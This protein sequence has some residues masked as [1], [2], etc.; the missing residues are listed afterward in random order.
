M[1]GAVAVVAA[2]I[3][4]TPADGGPAAALSAE[5][6]P[7][8]TAVHALETPLPGTAAGADPATPAAL[9]DADDGYSD[10]DLWTHISDPKNSNLPSDLFEVLSEVGATSYAPTPPA[11]VAFN[12]RTS[13]PQERATA[14]AAGVSKC[15]RQVL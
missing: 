11:S 2:V 12:G 6:E 10:T 15:T 4:W 8:S 7:A 9:E 14:R 5:L 13:G 1:V 3:W